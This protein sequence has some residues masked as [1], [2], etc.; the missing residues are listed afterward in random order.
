MRGHGSFYN[1]AAI[2]E[3]LAEEVAEYVS[4]KFYF[5]GIRNTKGHLVEGF[6][7]VEDVGDVDLVPGEVLVAGTAPAGVD[8]GSESTSI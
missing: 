1:F 7:G 5:D 6:P 2:P 4:A 8:T 3:A